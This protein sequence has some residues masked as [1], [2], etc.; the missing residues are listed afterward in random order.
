MH[1]R[2]PNRGLVF[3]WSIVV[4]TIEVAEF[5]VGGTSPMKTLSNQS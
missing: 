2:L 4:L 1:S 3:T 5:K